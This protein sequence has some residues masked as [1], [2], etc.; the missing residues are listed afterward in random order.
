MLPRFGKR[1]E[2]IKA[3]LKSIYTE[4]EDYQSDRSEKWEES[5][6]A[7]TFQANLDAVE[8][9]IDSLGNLE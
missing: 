5:E 1:L 3:N 4:M 2:V 7:E 8:E 9:A 6:A